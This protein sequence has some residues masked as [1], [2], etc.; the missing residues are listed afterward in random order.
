M[1]LGRE[2]L[3]REYQNLPAHI[4]YG[5]ETA[6]DRCYLTIECSKDWVGLV[7]KYSQS[8]IAINRLK[9]W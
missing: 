1:R 7:T 5:A 4:P 9:G 3:G 8:Q 2:T 6:I